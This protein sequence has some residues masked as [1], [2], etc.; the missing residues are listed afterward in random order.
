MNDMTPGIEAE[1]PTSGPLEQNQKDLQLRQKLNEAFL[2]AGIMVTKHAHGTDYITEAPELREA[3]IR[4]KCQST[5]NNEGLQVVV[6]SPD[7]DL[8]ASVESDMQEAIDDAG[9]DYVSIR[10]EK[11]LVPPRAKTGSESGQVGPDLSG[12]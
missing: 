1:K 7:R 5:F 3:G 4:I 11:P 6:H 10:Y 2:G 8:Y 9:I 12:G